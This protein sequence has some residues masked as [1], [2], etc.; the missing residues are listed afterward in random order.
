[1]LLITADDLGVHIGAYGDKTVATPH[2]DALAAAGTRFDKGYVTQASCS[3]SRASLLTGLFPMQNG[4]WGLAYPNSG[5]SVKPEIET[6]PDILNRAG[7]LTGIMG[8]LHIQPQEKFPFAWERSNDFGGPAKVDTTDLEAMTREAG[9]FL[10]RAKNE[11]K[12]FFLMA[13]YYD[14]H[15]VYRH[16]RHGLPEKPLRWKD[17]KPLPF[18]HVDTPEVREQIAAYYNAISRLD[19]GVGALLKTLRDQ[20]LEDNTLILFVGDNGA[21]FARGKV[22]AYEAGVHVPLLVKS[23]KGNA[24]KAT[25]EL[26]SSVDFFPTILEA[27]RL[28]VPQNLPGRS[29]TSVMNGTQIRNRDFLFTEYTAHTNWNFQPTR[30]VTDGR[31]KLIQRLVPNLPNPAINGEGDG[32][33]DAALQQFGPQTVE[34]AAWDRFVQPPNEEFF[35]LENDPDEWNDLA[36]KPAFAAQQ[37][38]LRLAL[39]AWRKEMNDPFLDAAFLESEAKKHAEILVKTAGTIA[40]FDKRQRDQALPEDSPL[41]PTQP[42][43]KAAAKQAE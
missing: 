32:A 25:R 23:P 15:R 29:L 39:D 40:T 26:T 22:S 30:T 9:E 33:L 4:Q 10:S 8:K 21:P 16:Q 43:A 24:V 27:A 28:P 13:N 42:A 31:F 1:M 2:L 5:Y 7:Y 14:P 6:L 37:S 36:G 38:H 20:G 17:V 3:P 12:P 19:S 18:Q 11:N 34:R 35:D 41:R